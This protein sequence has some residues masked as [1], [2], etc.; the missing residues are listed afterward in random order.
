MDF[1]LVSKKYIGIVGTLILV[2]LLSQSHFF[3]F[4]TETSLGR[5]I[6]LLL[7]IFISYTN[8]F[9]G[10]LAVLFII[11]AFNNND[12][13]Y[14][15]YGGSFYEGFDGS[16]NIVNNSGSSLATVVSQDKANIS[17]NKQNISANLQQK[18]QQVQQQVQQQINNSSQTAATTSSAAS[19]TST[20]S[21]GT[22]GFCILDKENNMLRGKQSNSVPVFNDSRQQD[23]NV[24]PSDKSIFSDSYSTF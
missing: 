8:K 15:F 9:L 22:E 18:K 20:S 3:D 16:G 1:R 19:T 11:I 2:V 7:I 17:Q 23:D 21:S 24:S 6:L 4:L 14:G 13:N 10:L 5:I 12:M